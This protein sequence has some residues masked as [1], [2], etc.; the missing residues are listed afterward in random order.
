MAIVLIAGNSVGSTALAKYNNDP[1]MDCNFVIS[2]L[3]KGGPCGSAMGF[4]VVEP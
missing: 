2:F 1:M 4:C 3:V